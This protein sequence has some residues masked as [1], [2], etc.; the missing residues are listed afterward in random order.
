MENHA[1]VLESPQTA[2]HSKK[3]FHLDSIQKRDGQ[4][5]SFNASKITLAIQ[6]AG[7][8]AGEFD[9]STAQTLT[10]RVLTVLA[11][12]LNQATPTVEN[13]QDVVEE[14]LLSSPF[15][16]T[17]KAYILYR[18][19]HA[20][21][22]DMAVQNEINLI[23]GYLE[24]LDWRVRENSN[25][26]YSLQGLNSHISSEMSKTYWLNRIYTQDVREAHLG[27]DFHLHD[28]GQLSVY[29]VG[30]DLHDLLS[31]GFRGVSGKAESL[32]AKHFRS[33]LGQ[34]VNF[35]YTL[36]GEA[37]G[38]QAFSN[39]DTYLAPFI[40]YDNLSYEEVRQSL[41][42]F[43]FNVNV[44]TRVGFQTPFTNVTL[45]LQP[46][47]W[48]KDQPVIIGGKHQKETYGDFGKE[49]ITFN[50]AFLDVLAE[51]DAKGRVFTFPIPTY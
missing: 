7:E 32:P 48:L 20:R 22:R 46:P 1:T 45:D 36:Q 33:A 25:M 13:V 50:R 51:G 49:M 28:L 26:A 10:L 4:V 41:Q 18:D 11:T 43:V 21:I 31:S 16:K 37:A 2:N 27:G 30:W 12:V 39:F 47:K 29:C 3:G 44:P 9:D 35:F 19:Q 23:D 40:R 34:I 38:A 8:A 15:K 17:A 42:E 5:V 6:R 14:V 24:Q